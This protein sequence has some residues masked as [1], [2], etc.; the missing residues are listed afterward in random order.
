[1][2]M[3]FASAD[4]MRATVNPVTSDVA[5]GATS[6]VVSILLK[7][8]VTTSRQVPITATLHVPVPNSPG[9]GSIVSTQTIVVTVNPN[10]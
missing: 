9:L 7:G 10:D 6:K 3:E 8:P 2:V 4:T 5:S 1:M